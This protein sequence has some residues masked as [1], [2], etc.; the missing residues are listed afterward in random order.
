MEISS[1][2]QAIIQTAYTMAREN[3]HEYLTPEH[4]LSAGL[5]FQEVQ[6]LLR[7][8]GAD[9]EEIRRLLDSYIAERIPRVPDDKDYEPVQSIGFEN[10]VERVLFHAESSS[11][12]IVESGDILAAIFDEDECQSAYILRKSGVT[13]YGLLQVVSSASREIADDEA[14]EDEA[15]R[16]TGKGRALDKFARE[17]TAAA[18]RGELEPLI[19]REDLLERMSLVLCRKLKHN[20]SLVGEPGVGKTAV[21]EGLAARIAEG[22]VPRLLRDYRLYS[23]DLGGMLAG[24]KYRGDFEERM[25]QV[26]RELEGEEKAILFIDEIHTIVGAG[27]VSG[28]SMDASNLLKP[29]L[30]GGKVRCIG[31]TTDDEFKKFF[32]KDRA[33]SRRFQKI[34]VPETTRDETEAILRGLKERYEKFHEVRYEDDAITA[35]VDLSSQYINDRH[36]PDKAIDVIDES[37]AWLQ[38]LDFRTGDDASSA[39]DLPVVTKD[40]VEKVVARIARIPE[41]SVSS[42]ENERLRTLDRQLQAVVFG[43]DDAIAAVVASIKRS[44]AGFGDQEK[45]V[46]SFLFVGPTGVGKTELARQL[47]EHLGIGLIRFDMSEYQERHSVSRLVGSPPGYVGYEEGGLLT[48]A[49]RKQPHAVLLLDEIEKAHRDVFNTLLQVM[50][51]AT[52]TDNSGRKA[53]FR[54]VIIIMTSNAGAREIGKPVIGFGDQTF[55]DSVVGK[56]VEE[57]FSPEFRNRLD[58]VIKFSHLPMEVVLMIVDKEI[59]AFR[60]RLEEKLVSL[61]VSQEAREWLAVNGYDPA[62]GAR[63]VSRLIQEKIK[64]FFVDAVLFGELAEGGKAVVDLDDDD[65]IAVRI[66]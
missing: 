7:E 66:G 3:R 51:Y 17:L 12:I 1:E 22:N 32:D 2:V 42:D 65:K 11:T 56:A 29:V 25:K 35:A 4:L 49:I 53:D 23:L 19:G 9:L 28:G 20:P 45:P 14:D 21:A 58:A 62:F 16:R 41:R 54:N 34:D 40:I 31:S 64:S 44:R 60:Q 36:Q 61:E 24:T 8:A 50:D 6:T 52:L 33:L 43:Q 10:I 15:R 39:E 26:L 59:S 18:E 57:A 46:A 63:N 38:M 55:S 37:G 27:A 48:D 30:A 47:A 5:S 13:R